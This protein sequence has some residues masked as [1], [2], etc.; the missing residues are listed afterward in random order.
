MRRDEDRLRD[1]YSYAK[2]VNNEKWETKEGAEMLRSSV[3][4]G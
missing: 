4:W 2:R 3:E 1:I